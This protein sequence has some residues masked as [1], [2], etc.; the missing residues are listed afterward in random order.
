M[1]SI[2]LPKGRLGNK[3]Y[4]FLSKCGYECEDMLSDT[5]KLV[6][7]NNE[8]GVS[9]FMVK[10]TDVP[11][12]VDYGA[13]DVGIVGKDSLLESG[14]DV[15]EVLDLNIGKCRMCVCG[16]SDF[17]DDRSKPLRVATKFPSIAKAYYGKNN[18]EVDIIK[19]SGSIEL[20]PILNISD[21]IV[22]LVETGTTLKENNL[23]VLEEVMPIS[24]RLIVNKASY[25]FKKAEID[26]LTKK[27]K[28]EIQND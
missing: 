21:V 15:Y 2:A 1:L 11:V 10:P 13:A 9:Y 23:V 3:V 24:A 5:R 27:L 14:Y 16:K 25:K 7:T 8:R 18:R 20:A 17:V 26:D 22:D 19:L 4:N 28:K 12:Y 6:L